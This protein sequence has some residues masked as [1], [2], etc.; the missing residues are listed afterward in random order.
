VGESGDFLCVD[1]GSEGEL[2]QGVKE[3]ARNGELFLEELSRVREA[4]PTAREQDSAG[5]A[6]SL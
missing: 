1:T 5:G 3:L 4:N 6:S 2:E